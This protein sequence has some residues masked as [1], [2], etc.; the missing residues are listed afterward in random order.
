MLFRSVVSDRDN[1]V[2]EIPGAYV[3][4]FQFAEF[5]EEE[6]DFDNELED[7]TE[8]MANIE[9]SKETKARIRAP[10][11]KTLIVKVYGRTVDFNYLTFK[12]NTLWKPSAI[13][14]CVNLGKD[15]F[16]IK[17]SSDDDYDKM[18]K[19]GLWM[20]ENTS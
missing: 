15:Y 3:K 17:F 7:L 10:W 2:G 8:G 1:L 20:W 18:L 14:D 9:L 6:D 16:L 11:S 4:A 13:M 12:I 5:R 19:G